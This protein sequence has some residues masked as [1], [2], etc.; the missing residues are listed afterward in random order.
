MNEHKPNPLTDGYAGP[1]PITLES[2]A[3]ICYAEVP[4]LEG[5]LAELNKRLAPTP[6]PDTLFSPE[7]DQLFE[8]RPFPASTIAS[9]E[10]GEV[11]VIFRQDKIDG[12]D[13]ITDIM[14][15]E[16]NGEEREQSEVEAAGFLIPSLEAIQE[17]LDT[18]DD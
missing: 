3:R 5:V 1:P 14:H 7:S 13:T 18:Y 17:R 4:G 11:T 8:H 6:K 9:M 16:L 10:F 12:R 15:Y 2:V